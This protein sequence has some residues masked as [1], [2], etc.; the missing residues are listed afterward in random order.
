MK[1]WF[2]LGQIFSPMILL[3]AY[4]L[5]CQDTAAVHS[6][7]TGL[8]SQRSK[9]QAGTPVPIDCQLSQW[10]EWTECFPCQGK[11]YRHRTLV[12]PAKYAGRRCTGSLWDQMDCVP[13]GTCAVSQDCGNDFRCEESGRCIKRHLVCNGEADCRDES[14]EVN[15][16]DAESSCDQLD[17]IPGIARLAQG[18]NILTQQGAQLVYD[19]AYYGGQCESVYNGEWRELKYDATCE[20]LYYGDDEKYFRR[21]Y[22]VHYYQFLAHADTGFSS[23]YFDD[24][25]DLLN[26][27]KR[28]TSWNAGFTFGISPPKVPVSLEI[29]FKLSKGKGTLKNITEY[30]SKNLAFVRVHTKVQTARFKM[31][32][33]DIVLDEDMFQSLMDL[34]DQYNYGM[35]SQFINTYGTHFMTSGTMGGVFEYILVINKDKMLKE[36]LS[37]ESVNSCFGASIGINVPLQETLNVKA[38]VSFDQC[39]KDASR[40]FDSTSSNSAIEDIIPLVQGGDAAS[41]GRLMEGSSVNAYRYWGRSLKLNPAVI[42]FELMPIDEILRRTNL[43]H[44][45]VKRKNMKRALDEYMTEFNACRC[46]PCQ[47]NGE[48]MMVATTC[49][50]EC[51]KGAQGPACENT[52]RAGR[53]EH[54]SWSCWAPSTSCQAGTRRR[55]RQCTNPAPSNGGRMCVGK[56]EQ[57]VAC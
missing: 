31:R 47:N 14:D 13:S 38:K 50:C 43:Q 18:Y 11:K 5:S 21:P 19:T 1:M 16:E 10:S 51:Q 4:L 39:S 49:D 55:T 48:P 34:P 26:A 36:E 37:K 3:I 27:I 8:P 52:Q 57:V 6:E 7:L 53:P 17:P 44:M 9:R 22:N 12:Q 35:Y 54:G 25:K 2:R 15:C 40:D 23:E 29:G 30:E 41:I 32:R 42:D 46:G 33:T 45:E 20:H 28:D 24:A 56:S